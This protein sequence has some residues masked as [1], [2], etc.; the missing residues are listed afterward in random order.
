MPLSALLKSESNKQLKTKMKAIPWKH[1]Q[2]CSISKYSLNRFC[3]NLQACNLL[4]SEIQSKKTISVG[5]NF[6]SLIL[7][8]HS[9]ICKWNLKKMEKAH[10][11]LIFALPANTFV[12]A[13]LTQC[14]HRLLC[15]ILSL[16]VCPILPSF[17]T[18]V[19]APKF[20]FV[21]FN[22]YI[23]SQFLGH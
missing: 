6:F 20:Q 3:T 9:P 15:N 8:K 4:N 18:Q 12:H 19:F 13:R 16:N 21:V 5:D 7:Y 22:N 17:E 10:T 11:Y 14:F 1:S 2:N 23:A